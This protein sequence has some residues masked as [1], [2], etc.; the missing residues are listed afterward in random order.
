LTD[1]KVID[2]LTNGTTELMLT[3][4]DTD[5]DGELDLQ[6]T[7][8]YNTVYTVTQDN[9]NGYGVDFNGDIDGDGD[10]DNTAT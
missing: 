1:V 4:G 8:I 3:S 10:I 7:W 2:P 5:A 6:E 9:I